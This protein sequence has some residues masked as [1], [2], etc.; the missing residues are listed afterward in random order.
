M[1]ELK[2]RWDEYQHWV[3]LD[4]DAVHPSILLYKEGTCTR[5]WWWE[6]NE[7]IIDADLHGLFLWGWQKIK[8]LFTTNVHPLAKSRWGKESLLC[9]RD[10]SSSHQPESQY[11]WMGMA[12]ELPAISLTGGC[13]LG[14]GTKNGALAHRTCIISCWRWNSSSP[15][16][17]VNA[18]SNM[19]GTSYVTTYSWL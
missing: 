14:H 6:E 19:V 15:I 4:H 2:H 5:W 17:A 18:Y 10:N 7:T 11:W 12:M 3:I 9:W 16:G 1:V 13:L 8:V